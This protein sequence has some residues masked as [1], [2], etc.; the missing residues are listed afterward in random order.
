MS[1][2]S[3][4]RSVLAY[5][6]WRKRHSRGK[7]A[8]KMRV[9]TL[10]VT[11]FAALIAFTLA[12]CGNEQPGTPSARAPQVQS[13]EAAGKRAYENH[14][15]ACHQASGEGLRGAFPPLKGNRRMLDDPQRSI[16]VVLKGLSGPLEVGGVTYNAVMPPMQHL[17][18]HDIAVALSYSYGAWGNPG[19]SFTADEVAARRAAR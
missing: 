6:P 11:T 5:F 4:T 7:E 16:D 15:A 1:A 3:Q 2:R 12:A 13:A 10:S 14:C 17:S 19:R 9:R 8:G 18:D